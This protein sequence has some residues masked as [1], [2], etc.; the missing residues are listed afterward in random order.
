MK[1]SFKCSKWLGLFLLSY[2]MAFPVRAYDNFCPGDVLLRSQEEVDQFNCSHISGSLI[3]EGNGSNNPIENLQGLSSLN[4]VDR[5]VIIRNQSQ[6]RTLEGLENL[7]Y[8][9]REL[10]ITNNQELRNLKGLEGLTSLNASLVIGENKNLYSIRGLDKLVQIAGS[11][12]IRNQSNMVYLNSLEKLHTIGGTFT[13][14]QLRS[15]RSLEELNQLEYLGALRLLD[16]VS[17]DRLDG[18]AQ[19]K[20]IEGELNLNGFD[21]V[22]E[23]RAFP[24]LSS[25][26]NIYIRDN[27]SL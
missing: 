5:D 7:S 19:L 27:I 18:F 1:V 2:L 8:I 24:V 12:E 9:G 4:R 22:A 6:L 20:V 25:V 15:L 17:L 26:G 16:L 3:I 10:Q 13:L 21:N 11:F 23:F 14:R